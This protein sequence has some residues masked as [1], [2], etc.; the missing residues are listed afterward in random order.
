MKRTKEHC[1]N[2]SKALKGKHISPETEFKVGDNLEEKHPRW[3][4]G[5]WQRK[6]DGRWFVLY[7]NNVMS[8]KRGY[9]LQSRLVM[10]EKLGRPLRPE[11]HV[12]H[13]DGDTSNDDPKNLELMTNRSHGK[14]SWKD[15]KGQTVTY[16]I[17]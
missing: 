7:P 15:R 16:T 3:K 17:K 1:K 14:R 9:V 2:L 4:G 11:E 12:H 13:I 5:K 10:S 8:N 6:Q